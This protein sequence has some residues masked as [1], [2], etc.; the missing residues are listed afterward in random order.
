MA[1]IPI[2]GHP[3][4]KQR[5]T[6]LAGIAT[7]MRKFIERVGVLNY[8]CELCGRR[9]GQKGQSPAINVGDKK[10]VWRHSPHCP[11]YEDKRGL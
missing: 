8:R 10:P 6:G 4:R 11:P 3:E 5:T 1:D 7:K 9:I 2:L